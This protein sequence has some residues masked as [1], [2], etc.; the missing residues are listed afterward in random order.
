MKKGISTEYANDISPLS[1]YQW[2]DISELERITKLNSA[3]KFHKGF[4]KIHVTKAFLDGQVTINLNE[5]M[6]ASERGQF[7]LDIEDFLKDQIDAGITIWHESIGDKNSLRNL[8]GID[9][10]SNEGNL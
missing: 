1:S 10:I 5:V 6:T 4:N 8:R 3:L 9:V 2:R 7:L